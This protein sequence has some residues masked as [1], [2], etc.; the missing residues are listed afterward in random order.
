VASNVEGVGS[1]LRDLVWMLLWL[2]LFAVPVG[3]IVGIALVME[4]FRKPFGSHHALR[5]SEDR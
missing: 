3:I 1:L 5:E 4:R 2:P